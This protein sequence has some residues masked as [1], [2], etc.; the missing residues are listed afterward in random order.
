MNTL[1]I[2]NWDIW[3][4]YRRDRGQPPWIKVHRRLTQD[5]NWVELTDAERGQLVAIWIL[6]ADRD[7]VIPASA[8]LLK[9]LCFLSEEPDLQLFVEKGFIDGDAN[10]TPERRQRDVPE[11]SRVEESRGDSCDRKRSRKPVEE[12]ES[13]LGKAF[14]NYNIAAQEF[15]LPSAKKLTAERQRKLKARLDEYGLEGW[16]EALSKLETSSFLRGEGGN[17]WRADFDFFLQ[18]K[19][20]TRALEGFYD[21]GR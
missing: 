11:E 4:S 20:L 14:R 5:I 17:G 21:D 19:S 3:Q 9:K 16:N 8:P 6:A 2:R 10:V 12:S 15:S 13:Q 1:R 18:P 7:G